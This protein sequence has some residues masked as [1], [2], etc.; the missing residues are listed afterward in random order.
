VRSPDREPFGIDAVDEMPIGRPL[1]DLDIRQA[2]EPLALAVGGGA[3]RTQQ[4][5]RLRRNRHAGADFH[6]A[7]N[8]AQKQMICTLRPAGQT[9]FSA[10][11]IRRSG[12]MEVRLNVT[13][14]VVGPALAHAPCC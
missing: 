6:H 11:P 7:A 12:R 1:L 4:A 2:A 3:S 5:A 14:C 9:R 8:C 13:F 10:A